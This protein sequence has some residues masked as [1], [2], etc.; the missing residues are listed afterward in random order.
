MLDEVRPA[1]RV[2]PELPGL[3]SRNALHDE[4][5]RRTVPALTVR[6]NHYTGRPVEVVLDDIESYRWPTEHLAARLEDELP[7][8]IFEVRLRVP[9]YA[10]AIA[11]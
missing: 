11:G 7:D 9:G 8:V 5:R 10:P 1:R 3:P 6:G 4:P 2:R